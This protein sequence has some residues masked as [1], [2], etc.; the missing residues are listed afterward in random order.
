MNWTIEFLPFLPIPYLVG[1]GIVGLLITLVLIW[2][3]RRGTLLRVG[4]LALLILALANPNLKEEEREKLAN[5]AVVMVDQSASQRIAGRE[6]RTAEIRS[7]LA[8]RFGSLDQLEVRW[9]ESSGGT[10]SSAE[11]TTLFADLN[12]ALSDIPAER[13]AGVVMLTDGQIHD[14]PTEV[15]KLG[16]DAP[17]HALIVG[18]PNE[19]DNR[20]EVI[21]APRFGLVGS[22]QTVE[23]RAVTS[24]KDGA[25]H[26]AIL[27]VRRADQTEETLSVPYGDVV[28][29]PFPFPHAGTTLMEVELAGEDGELT[30]A[31]N[32]VALQAEGVRE[33][34]RVLLV[35]GEPHAGERTWRNLL[36]S[37]ASVDLVHFTI[38]R[39]PEKQDG[40]PINQLSLIAFPTRELFSEKLS[41][42]DLIIFDRYQRR[43]VLP[44]IYLDNV[45][46]Y[47][48]DGGA[49]L[50]A[51][52]S[53]YAGDVSLF[54]TPLGDVLPAQPTGRT[55]E[56]PF[57]P[58]VTEIGERHPVTAGLPGANVTPEEEPHWGRWFR[59]VESTALEGNVVMDGPD[60]APL[61]ILSRRGKGRVAT[62]LSDHVWLWARGYEGG[63]PHSDLLRRLSHWLMK[64]PDLEEEYLKATADRQGIVLERRSMKD[65]VGEAT[66]TTPT[67]KSVTVPMEKVGPGLWRG[68]LTATEPGLHKI[69]MDELTAVALVGAANSREFS[70]VAATDEPI[71]PIADATGGGQFWM[72]GTNGAAA[73][74]L[75]RLA[76]LQSATRYHGQNWLGLKDREAY[77]VRGV[78]YT[79]L[80]S[81]YLALA[82]FLGMIMLTWFRESR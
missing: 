14:V 59:A 37:D 10:S 42:F 39:P 67:D 46:R 51:A 61:L 6:Q 31:N 54:R 43:G 76:M 74:D 44:L 15:K 34:L 22:E 78:Q 63:G 25:S 68:R 40:T 38:L 1:A 28:K 47:V 60:K 48:E 21:S 11:E 80:L 24:R 18:T 49:V 23:L 45:A 71:R 5:I 9:V 50:V 64:E 41:E 35:S 65:E 77:V 32:R 33:N 7:Q 27:R 73:R 75:P 70:K 2:R 82:L 8:T 36:R 17:V 19:F 29:L 56:Q 20:L 53:D 72:G 57:R 62:F 58:K 55:I 81:G 52:G 12:R 16:F 4:S 26:P 79:P 30:L 66:V 3:G 13:L 69:A